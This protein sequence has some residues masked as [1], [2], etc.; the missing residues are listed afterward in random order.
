MRLKNLEEGSFWGR[1]DLVKRMKDEEKASGMKK[2]V[3]VDDDGNHHGVTT[4]DKEKW[5]ELKAQG[6]KEDENYFNEAKVEVDNEGNIAGY[7]NTIDEYVE[8]LFKSAKDKKDTEIAYR[9]Q[10]AVDD[11]RMRELGLKPSNIRSKFNENDA[12]KQSEYGEDGPIN[13]KVRNIDNILKSMGADNPSDIIADIMHWLDAHPDEDLGSLIRRANGYYHNEKKELNEFNTPANQP[14]TK[15][16]AALYKQAQHMVM[17][18]K[19]DQK[20]SVEM[21][22]IVNKDMRDH[23]KGI[24]QDATKLSKAAGISRDA[25]KPPAPLTQRS[26]NFKKFGKP[27]PFA[28][29]NVNE[30]KTDNEK[31]SAIYNLRMSLQSL[32]D[33]VNELADLDN[34]PNASGRGDL[35][36][37]LATMDKLTSGFEAVLGRA[38]DIVPGDD[39]GESKSEGDAWY[40]EQD[41]KRMAEKDGH[42]WSS[43]PYGRKSIYRNKAAEMRKGDDEEDMYEGKYKNDAQRKAV[44]ANKAEKLKVREAGSP[45]TTTGKHPEKMTTDELWTEIAVFD[46]L[47]DRGETLSPKDMMRL[48]SLFSYMDTAEMNEAIKRKADS[49]MESAM[50]KAKKQK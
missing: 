22:N 34:E 27:N 6:Y 32:K 47:Q 31:K 14:I 7:L 49:M 21:M 43:L 1:D 13:H 3:K 33:E 5:E 48:D 26:G 20:P 4:S 35:H 2:F 28:A 30:D 29:E 9:I 45:W 44:H 12:E 40:I 46:E 24:G 11:I 18:S 50:W 17:K 8:M 39:L 10:N 42:D 15:K 37:Q 36:D 41:A 38:Y 19:I 23:V 16:D 25:V